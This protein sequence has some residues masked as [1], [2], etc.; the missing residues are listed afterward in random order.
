M[1]KTG[2]NTSAKRVLEI[3]AGEGGQDARVF[4]SELAL[5]YLKLAAGK[6]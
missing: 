1:S 3:R 5:A 6:G 2:K 4:V